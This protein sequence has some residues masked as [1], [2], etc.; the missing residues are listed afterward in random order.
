MAD[1]T[2]SNYAITKPEVGASSDSWGDKLNTD[3]DTIDAA[4]PATARGLLH[5]LTLSAAGSTGTFGIAAGRCVDT[6]FAAIMTLASAYTKTT[7][8]WAVGSGNGGLDTGSIANSTWYHV[9][10]IKRVDTGVTD[11]IF[12][13]SAS[14]PTLPTNY[15]LYRR[16]GAMA[17]D[18]SAHWVKFSQVGDEFLW[19]TPVAD[20]AA[21]IGTTATLEALSVPPGYRV[22]A[23]FKGGANTGTTA[24]I[25]F[26]SPDQAV[27]VASQ[28]NSDLFCLGSGDVVGSFNVRTNAANQIRIVTTQASCTVRVTTYGWIDRRGRDS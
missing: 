24:Y 27:Q 21:T 16:I 13:T 8:A 12:S 23:L 19:D 2:T 28:S 15:T 25:L 6:T 14:A 7:S 20:V 5:G 18:G 26:T 9:Y 17:T 22:N 11:I 1:A 3:M 4:I 10:A